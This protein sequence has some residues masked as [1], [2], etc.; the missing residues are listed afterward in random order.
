MVSVPQQPEVAVAQRLASNER[1]VRTRALKTLKKY[2][3]L[4]SQTGGFCRD[5][6]LKIWKGLFYSLWMQDKPDLQEELSD[7]VSLLIHSFHTFNNQLLYFETFLQTMKREWNGIDRLRMDKFFQLVRF[8]FRQVF[9]VLKRSEWES[10]L[11]DQF[12]AVFTA[13]LLQSA[14]RV[15]DGLMLHILELYMTELAHV[16]SAE[17]KAEQNLTFIQPF[18]KTISETKD[19]SVLSSVCKHIFSTILDHASYAVEELMKELSDGGEDSG[20]AEEESEEEEET[21]RRSLKKVKDRFNGVSGVENDDEDSYYELMDLDNEDLEEDDSDDVG[22]VLQFDYGA[23]ADCLFELGSRPLTPNFN[24]NKIYK[25]VKTFRD[26]SEG[27]FPQ[28]D[29]ADAAVK[30]KGSKKKKKKGKKSA[31]QRDDDKSPAKKR[32]ACEV[33]QTLIEPDQDEEPPS[34]SIK[35]KKKKNEGSETEQSAETPQDGQ[36]TEEKSERLAVVVDSET[37]SQTQDHK[38][39]HSE[40][41]CSVRKKGKGKIRKCLDA[42]LLE[43]EDSGSLQTS[44]PPSVR[45]KSG[46]KSKKIQEEGL[47]PDCSNQTLTDVQQENDLSVSS[48]VMK[49]KKKQ[50]QK[51]ATN[52]EVVIISET[53]PDVEILEIQDSN[54]P[55]FSETTTFTKKRRE[56]AVSKKKKIK[57]KDDVEIITIPEDSSDTASATITTDAADAT[58]LQSDAVSP[59][60]KK[61]KNKKQKAKEL[62]AQISE[63]AEEAV[64][65]PEVAADYK[66]TGKGHTRTAEEEEAAVPVQTPTRKKKSQ[67]KHKQQL[68][69]LTEDVKE[70]VQL[71]DLSEEP[72]QKKSRKQKQK[73]EAAA[74]ATEAAVESTTLRKTKKKRKIQADEAETSQINGKAGTED[75]EISTSVKSKKKLKKASSQSDFASFQSQTAVP[76]PLFCRAKP[77]GKSRTGASIQKTFLKADSKKVTFGLKNNKTTEF[78]TTDQ[79]LLVSPVGSSRVAFDPEKKPASGVLKSPSASPFTSLKKATPKKRPTAADF[80]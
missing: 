34:V 29:D 53:G 55:S 20:A 41:E 24:R 42:E 67:K 9:E 40:Q 21:G 37:Q 62:A 47:S 36:E 32:K 14:V 31:V 57:A 12:L 58:K 8:V 79:S 6:L 59:T 48:P 39:L 35:K 51:S 76:T 50:K 44:A 7:R 11:V 27:I 70:E 18:C 72:V 65:E 22:P 69:E 64:E 56:G 26:L 75:L 68:L 17:L 4:R 71:P 1:P 77:K 30:P 23:L 19:R 80:F 10:S 33:E 74:E 45:K 61:R 43:E 3:N 5:D 38:G 16:G 2:I 52:D 25:L 73:T 78:R 15:P 66:P 13:E 49:K 46:K 28:D 54:V 63:P 60:P